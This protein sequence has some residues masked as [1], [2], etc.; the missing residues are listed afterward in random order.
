MYK[1]EICGISEWNGKPISL[2]LHHVDG[3]RKN[4][5]LSNIQILCPNCHSQT[6]NYAGKNININKHK[7]CVDKIKQK[8]EIPKRIKQAPP[9]SREELKEKIR[10]VPFVKIGKEL[11]VTDN[12]VRRWCD[13]Y[14]LPRKISIIRKY[15]DDEWKYI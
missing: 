6:D 15:S 7:N 9:I 13:K 2:Q 10:H 12:A 14:G 3:N 8:I 4:N 1:C 5:L 11:G